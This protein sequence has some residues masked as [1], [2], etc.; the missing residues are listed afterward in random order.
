MA[1][2]NPDTHQIVYF[3]PQ[4]DPEF[5]NWVREDCGCCAGIKWGGEEPIECNNCAGSGYV[6]RHKQ[7]GVLAQWP[8]GPFLGR[9][10]QAE[11][12]QD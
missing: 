7:S 2:W 11:I 1:H 8:G 5:P 6:W 12:L 9:L 10:T 4:E 3:P